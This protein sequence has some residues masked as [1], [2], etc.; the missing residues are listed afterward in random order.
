MTDKFLYF[1]G[2]RD[3]LLDASDFLQGLA[4]NPPPEVKEL[5][6]PFKMIAD[7]MRVKAESSLE[8]AKSFGETQQ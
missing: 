4:D 2:F 8:F 3:G 6:E 5:V 1:K 7:T